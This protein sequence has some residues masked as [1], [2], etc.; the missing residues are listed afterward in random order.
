MKLIFN[1]DHSFSFELIRTLGY[2]VSGG[3]DLGEC[4][5]TA[6][7]IAEG[8]FES[9]HRE[10]DALARSV[11]GKAEAALAD[12]DRVGAREAYLRASNYHRT[13]EFFLHG[14]IEDPRI[15]TSWG[16]ARET[17]RNAVALM[18]HP[19]EAVHVPFEDTSLPA[20]FF[21]P[22][23][24]DTAR[25]TLIVHGGYDS[26]G[27]ELYLE[28]GAAALA[29]G[30]NVLAIEGP[31]QGAALREQGF[32]FRK[33]W[34]TVVTPAIDWLLDQ[35][36]VDA[37][38][39]A[40]MGV[41]LGGFLAPRAAAFEHRL[42]ALIANDGM[43]SFRFGDKAKAFLKVEKLFGRTMAEWVLRRVMKKNS[44]VRWAIENG[45]FTFGAGD[46]WDMVEKTSDWTL[47]GIVEN[48]RCP[49]LVCE[50][51]EDHFFV[52]QPKALFDAL[53]CPKEFLL[54]KEEDGAGEHCQFGGL[55]HYN[56]Q[57][58]TWLDQTL[59]VRRDAAG[60]P[61]ARSCSIAL[62]NV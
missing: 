34:E 39:I 22:A 50:A 28:I 2:A 30:Y 18:D 61:E 44:G 43:F 52:G 56:H 57:V 4:L 58:F 5:R 9:W 11:E 8:D 41:S 59:S 40:L 36:G 42:A 14:D 47:D 49:T 29:R 21:R 3:A 20:Y 17:F 27:E 23:A 7:R 31:G 26:I 54:C 10:W 16:A 19:A 53:R 6:N 37:G 24:D 13:A 33:E 46:V 51:E 35:P 62:A 45:C 15:M 38:R 60:W 32:K 12:G 48:I 1:N 25:P 55:A